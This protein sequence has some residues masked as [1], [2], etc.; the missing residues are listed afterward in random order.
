MPRTRRIR[1]LDPA[2]AGSGSREGTGAWFGIDRGAEL[3]RPRRHDGAGEGVPGM[4]G[5]AREGAAPAAQPQVD[6]VGKHG[7]RPAH[8]AEGGAEV[9]A[10]PGRRRVRRADVAVVAAGGAVA[11][12]RRARIDGTGHV[13]PS[14]RALRILVRQ[15]RRGD[16]EQRQWGSDDRRGGHEGVREVQE[17]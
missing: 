9:V 7:A 17:L 5:S 1:Y 16:A 2:N 15:H 4:I 10:W 11:G 8:A 3:L 14:D 6:R 12:I 13:R